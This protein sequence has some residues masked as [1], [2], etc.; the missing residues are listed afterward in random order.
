MNTTTLTAAVDVPLGTTPGGAPVRWRLADHTGRPHHG[1]VAGLTASGGTTALA[2]IAAGAHQAGAATALFDL[3]GQNLLHWQDTGVRPGRVITQTG[4]LAA[5]LDALVDGGARAADR[6]PLVVLVDGP[7]GLIG[8]AA[9][10]THLVR[11]SPLLNVA[12]VARVYAPG[13]EEFGSALLRDH[14]AMDQHLTL[15][16]LRPTTPE[17]L[18]D[19]LPGYATPQGPTRAGR[20]VHYLRGAL[21]QVTVTRP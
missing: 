15:G 20:G 4:E 19:V 1:L 12:V 9:R 7:Q 3:A 13:L 18:A 8:E 5:F 14:L 2:R 21:S 10:W 17:V 11:R 6:E 16:R